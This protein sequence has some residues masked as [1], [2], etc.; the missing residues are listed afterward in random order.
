MTN[1]VETNLNGK[2]TV[3]PQLR[4]H[5]N[6]DVHEDRR[7]LVPDLGLGILE[8]DGNL[9]IHGGAEVKRAVEWMRNLPATDRIAMD[10]ESVS[11]FNQAA[12]QASDQIKACIKSNMLSNTITVWIVMVGP[13]FIFK[14]WGP[15]TPA[16]LRTRGHRPNDSGDYT[17]AN[18]LREIRESD[19]PITEPIYQ[20]KTYESILVLYNCLLHGAGL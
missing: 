8:D 9:S 12:V 4:V 11:S 2:T 19:S 5:W 14:K 7:S 20:L 16:E 6:P 3:F 10:P 17:V 18:K 15:F 13:Y 1:S